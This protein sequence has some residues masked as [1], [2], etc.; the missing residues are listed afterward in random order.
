MLVLTVVA[1][2]VSLV[3]LFAAIYAWTTDSIEWTGALSALA[4]A[5]LALS[6]A[7][8]CAASKQPAEEVRCSTIEGAKYSSSDKACYKNGVKLDF[9]EDGADE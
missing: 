6:L 5:C 2:V 8:G 7:C 3:C 9:N 1:A 4:I